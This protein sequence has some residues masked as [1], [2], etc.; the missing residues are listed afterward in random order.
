[1]YHTVSIQ[2]ANSDFMSFTVHTS[3]IMGKNIPKLCWYEFICTTVY[4]SWVASAGETFSHSVEAHNAGSELKVASYVNFFIW[5]LGTMLE[6]QKF[7]A[8]WNWMKGLLKYPL[9]ITIA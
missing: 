7:V 5:S 4:G 8:P 6:P 1:M 9:E 2:N 3:D